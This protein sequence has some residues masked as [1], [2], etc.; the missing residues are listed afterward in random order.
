MLFRLEHWFLRDEA[1]CQ[2][3]AVGVRKE[4]RVVQKFRKNERKMKDIHKR[5]AVNHATSPSSS[6]WCI[7]I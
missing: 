6:V 7:P 2:A 5:Q 3:S 4:N 1:I